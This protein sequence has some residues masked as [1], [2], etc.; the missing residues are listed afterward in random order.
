MRYVN[1]FEIPSSSFDI[2]QYFNLHPTLGRGLPQNLASFMV[3]TVFVFENGRDNMKVQF[4]DRP[5]ISPEKIMFTL[6]MDYFLV[7]PANS[8]QINKVNQWIA[9]AHKNV[10]NIFEA[11]LTDK[12][13]ALFD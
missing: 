10:K 13:K 12:S 2:E 6:D 5:A 9:N 3:G 8:V 7:N 4:F 1:N 11:V